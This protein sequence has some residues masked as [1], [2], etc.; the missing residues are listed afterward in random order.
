MLDRQIGRLRAFEDLIYVAGSPP[1][2]LADLAA[3]LV[4]LKVDALVT[5]GTPGTLAAKR[6]TSTIPIVMATSGDAVAS[7]LIASLARPGGNVTGM[8]LLLPELSVKRL[9]LLKQ[10]MPRIARLA[11]LFNPLNPA[12]VTDIN[13]TAF[14]A[15]SMKVEVQRFGARAPSEFDS[16]FAAMV[17]SHVEAVMVHQD[18]MLNGNSRAISDLARKHRLPSIGFKEFGEAGGLIGYGVSF[19]EMYRR[20]AA[21]VDKLL[22]GA[23]P[24]DLPV[25]QP[26]KFELVINLKTAKALGVTVPQSLLVRADQVIE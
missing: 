21:Y 2:L 10:L 15:T 13:E 11:V 3:E 26:A 1:E 16:V 18:G 22:K 12:F 7:G 24:G 5:H 9:E 4:A 19:L 14:A 8:T 25:E 6:A 23:R 20:A 17:K